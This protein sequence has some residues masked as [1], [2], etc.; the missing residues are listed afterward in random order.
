MISLKLYRYS[1][2]YLERLIKYVPILGG[3]SNKNS[4]IIKTLFSFGF[5]TELVSGKLFPSYLPILVLLYGSIYFFYPNVFITVPDEHN[6]YIQICKTY[7]NLQLNTILKIFKDYSKYFLFVIIDTKFI[8]VSQIKSLD[9]INQITIVLNIMRILATTNEHI[10]I[11]K[12]HSIAVL[13]YLYQIITL[14]L[15]NLNKLIFYNISLFKLFILCNNR[16]TLNK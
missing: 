9:S 11:F 8:P 14:L 13:N 12:L 6:K 2:K 3:F 10:F 7:L 16:S 5:K 15:N 1:F 4:Q